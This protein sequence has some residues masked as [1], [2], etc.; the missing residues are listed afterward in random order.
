MT[1]S[2]KIQCECKSDCCQGQLQNA[3]SWFLL[4]IIKDTY[5]VNP[6]HA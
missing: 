2:G 3:V 4:N 5:E 1:Q 6:K